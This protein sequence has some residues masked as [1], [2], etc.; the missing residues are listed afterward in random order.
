MF[1]HEDLIIFFKIDGFKIPKCA[2]NKKVIFLV[3]LFLVF[4][5]CPPYMVD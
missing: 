5:W 2:H 3:R 1:I 4:L